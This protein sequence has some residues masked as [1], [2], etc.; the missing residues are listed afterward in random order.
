M[1]RRTLTARET[2]IYNLLLQGSGD[3]K[4]A[5]ELGVSWHTVRAAVKNVFNKLG[6]NSRL[7]LVVRVRNHE[8]KHDSA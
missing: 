1:P 2:Q 7:E 5:A 4:I 6:V 8:K 3:K